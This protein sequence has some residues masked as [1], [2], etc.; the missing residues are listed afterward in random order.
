MKKLLAMFLLAGLC[1]LFAAPS[2]AED[3]VTLKPETIKDPGIILSKCDVKEPD[4]KRRGGSNDAIK[5]T[6]KGLI[7]PGN[8]LAFSAAKSEL[9]ITLQDK[10]YVFSYGAAPKFDKDKLKLKN[11]TYSPV[12]MKLD[13]GCKY[14]LAFPYLTGEGMKKTVGYRS[15]CA[16]SVKVG[17]AEIAFY[18]N[19]TDGRY[20][21]DD[22]FGLNDGMVFAPITEKIGTADGVYK[23]IS[24]AEDGSSATIAKLEEPVGTI[25]V[26]FSGKSLEAHVAFVGDNGVSFVTTCDGK[27]VKVL[28]GKYTIKYGLLYNKKEK[29]AVAGILAGKMGDFEV[30][31]DQTVEIK[32]GE[33]FVLGFDVEASKNVNK[34]KVSIN[35]SAFTLSGRSAEQ[36]IGYTIQRPPVVTGL[37]E[38]K[39]EFPMGVFETG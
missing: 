29:C 37:E 28:P 24:I 16:V 3:A 6:E 12:K 4:G 26:K 38:G 31:A 35:P 15:G 33:D 13:N 36:Y 23:V 11:G 1:V 19:N 25:A 14:V 10:E 7:A 5:L 32:L 2:F 18:D 9:P 34:T 39:K 30:A 8:T 21:L 22:T 20:S 17:M 27:P